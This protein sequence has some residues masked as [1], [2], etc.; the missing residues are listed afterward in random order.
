MRV[1]IDWLRE[2]V[3]VP[4]DATGEQIAAD[5]RQPSGSRRRACTPVV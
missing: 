1:P 2:Y 4:H 3:A 5:A